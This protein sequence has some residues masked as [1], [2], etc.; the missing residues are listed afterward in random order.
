M[1]A[2]ERASAAWTEADRIGALIEN[3]RYEP[4]GR[5]A[6]NPERADEFVASVRADRSAR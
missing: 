5:V 2:S 3:A 4:L 1:C 6:L